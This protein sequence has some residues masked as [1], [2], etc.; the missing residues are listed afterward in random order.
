MPIGDNS[1][2]VEI[3]D[4]EFEREGWK[5]GRYKGTKLTSA[6]INKFTPGD[7]TFGKE[8][9]IEQFSKTVYVFNQ[10]NNS[11]E[12]NAGI[13]YPSTD[14][15]EQ[16]LPNKKIIG[17]TN[18]KID[19]AVT[20]TIG[21]PRNFSQIEPGTTKEDPSFNYF[22]TLLKND[23]ALFNS[24]SVRFFDNVNNG[25]VKPTYIVGY[26]RGE[27]KPAVAYFQDESATGTNVHAVT[28]ESQFDYELSDNG[29]LYINPNVEDW[30]IAQDGASG[31]EGTILAGNTS[32]T[33]NHQ[34]DKDTVNSMEGYFFGLSKRLL[35][36]KDPYYISFDKGVQGVGI[37]NEKNIIKAFDIHELENSGS[38]INVSNNEFSIKTSGRYGSTFIGNYEST[39]GERKEEFI[40]F[41]EK[42]TNNN[43]H[44]D[45]NLSVEAPAGVGNGGVIIPDNLHPAIK[46][47]LNV[48]LGNAGLGAQG[49]TTAQFGLGGAVQSVNTRA[50][51]QQATGRIS[52]Q[53]S[54]LDE[55][56]EG[57]V[58]RSTRGL[59]SQIAGLQFQKSQIAGQLEEFEAEQ[60]A[61][62]AIAVGA[63][64]TAE[65][66]AASAAAAELAAAGSLTEAQ[67]AAQDAF[68][69][70]G[71]AAEAAAAAEAAGGSA[72]DAVAA[73]QDANLGAQAAAA[74]A[75][76]AG[77]EA[78]AAAI[79]AA[80]AG[81]NAVQAALDA[82]A[83][84]AEA[85]AAAAAA[86][87]VQLAED[88]QLSLFSAFQET[89]TAFGAENLE[90]QEQLELL[91]QTLED[92]GGGSPGEIE[93]YDPDTGLLI[94]DLVFDPLDTNQDGIVSEEEL[95]V[96]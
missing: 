96:S 65:E 77:D 83:S 93:L 84:L 6:K 78:T 75:L 55:L 62:R 81:D 67:Q 46:E 56:A 63:E 54:P 87:Q 36:K 66:A 48:Y 76:A 61:V 51:R 88:T 4:S 17:A 19:R 27:F 26:N 30:F 79:S 9:V 68:L 18:F 60:T 7:V 16:T 8:P 71:S 80:T 89:L 14:E 2:T 42:V 70:G 22:D 32:I 95:D 5:R 91:N 74:A 3:N 85:E 21:D 25:F 23:L 20:F 41:R 58:Q 1:Y 53:G 73:A 49:G 69:A 50:S 38:N 11:F 57:A 64:S 90:T 94:D 31:S 43:V 44:L 72:A 13:F 45:F 28:G 40:I 35:P 39:T 34:G 47:S 24:C 52:S 59:Q 82:G 29:R 37:F 10:A 12:T 15:F 33:I 86:V 92:L